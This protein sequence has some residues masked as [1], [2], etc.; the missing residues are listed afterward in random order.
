MNF[1][2]KFVP[3]DFIVKEVHNLNVEHENKSGKSLYFLLKKKNYE[4]FEAISIISKFLKIDKKNIGYAG[5]K[6][7]DGITEQYI[8]IEASSLKN[9]FYKEQFAQLNIAC[10]DSKFIKL[11]N[12]GKTGGRIDVA[13]LEGNSFNITVRDIDEKMCNNLRDNSIF[14]MDFINYYD[15]QRFGIPNGEKITHILG[16]AI[17]RKDYASAVTLINLI[18]D[19]QD[20]IE[21]PLN[22]INDLFLRVD[23]KKL[24]FYRSSYSSFNWNNQII[25]ILENSHQIIKNI[26]SEIDGIKFIFPLSIDQTLINALEDL[27]YK[28]RRHVVVDNQIISMETDRPAIISTNVTLG[29]IEKDEFH[30]GKYKFSISFF[31]PAGCY[32]TMLIRQ[33]VA[34]LQ[35]SNGV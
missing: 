1:K 19:S 16:E 29:K 28:Y 24:A 12:I 27:Q 13:S 8:S 30:S 21:R 35:F 5:L 31:L 15:T 32:A 33:L 17:E 6:D 10:C 3:E 7:C 22:G 25:K 9:E 14:R 23:L 34:K 18:K 20:I 2:L 4:T 11:N 26:T